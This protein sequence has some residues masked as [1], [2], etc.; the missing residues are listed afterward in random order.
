M[1]RA[2][3]PLRADETEQKKLEG[4]QP[5]TDEVKNDVEE[6]GKTG[7]GDQEEVIK[8]P[9]GPGPKPLAEIA[10]EHGGDAGIQEGASK[11]ADNKDGEA[12]EGAVAGE[13]GKEQGTGEQYVKT[14]GLAADGG[15][16]D[17]TKPGAGREAD[18]RSYP[19]PVLST[20]ESSV[21]THLI[22]ARIQSSR[23]ETSRVLL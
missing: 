17:A 22:P 19:I 3:A 23:E 13:D 7:A 20:F 5:A 12:V 8:Q 2:D 21:A 18:R 1:P 4:D 15:D 6:S 16:F 10:R 9:D 11:D 14:S